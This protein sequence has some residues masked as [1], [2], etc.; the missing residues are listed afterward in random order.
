[1]AHANE[2]ERQQ[3]R[4]SKKVERLNTWLVIKYGPEYRMQ[5]M[6]FTVNRRISRTKRHTR[7]EFGLSVHGAVP[8]IG[9]MPFKK[10]INYL[11]KELGEKS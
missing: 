7:I 8:Q 9:P 10:L 11:N 6:K 4:L 2:E 5:L 1:M 3:F